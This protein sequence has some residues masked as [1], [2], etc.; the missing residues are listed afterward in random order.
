MV[1]FRALCASLVLASAAL[2]ATITESESNGASSN[3]TIA[4][5]QPVPANAFTTPAPAGVFNSSTPTATIK[6]LGGGQDVDFYRFQGSGILQ[7]SITDIPYTFAP[8]VSLFD[9]TGRLLAYDDSSTPLKPGSVSTND[10]Y[11]GAFTL[12]GSGTYYAAVS[13]ADASI[14]NYPDSSSCTGTAA[15]VRPDGGFG[16]FATTGCAAPSSSFFLNGPQ[17]ANALAYT[18]Q[19]A[20]TAVPEPATVNLA[21]EALVLLIAGACRWRRP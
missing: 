21:C 10:S 3:D 18:L 15:L 20:Q 14:P 5:A 8:I 13:S 6:G 2:C 7:L 19:I 12:P 11:V 1:A 17:P 16:G 9:S 4:S